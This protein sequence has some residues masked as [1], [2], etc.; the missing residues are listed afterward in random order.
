[1]PRAKKPKELVQKVP[2]VPV[3]K[4]TIV[5]PKSKIRELLDDDV[6]MAKADELAQAGFSVSS[7]AS[8]LG[9]PGTTFQ[10]W[11]KMGKQLQEDA[12]TDDTV[13][14]FQRLAKS[15]A[16]ARGLAELSLLQ[17][18]P[19]FYLTRGPGALLGD[20]WAEESK[21]EVKDQAQL[22]VGSQFID[23]LKLLRKQGYDLNTIIDNDTL[24]LN[25]GAPNQATN[26]LL[27]QK[28]DPPRFTLPGELGKNV[29]ELE[30]VL[31]LKYG[32]KDASSQEI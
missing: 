13:I 10:K 30:Q 6:K 15:W 7:I 31:D 27:E 32:A 14:L 24:A 8:A 25:I 12:P 18:N 22:E 16:T 19:E 11:I 23:A 1:M 3:T 9:I 20:D 26:N 29:A 17:R 2:E 21:E 4:I 5:E 28:V